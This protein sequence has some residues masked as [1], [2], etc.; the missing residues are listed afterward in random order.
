V[1]E[2]GSS[3]FNYFVKGIGRDQHDGDAAESDSHYASHVDA[4]VFMNRMPLTGMSKAHAPIMMGK[5]AFG[6][7]PIMLGMM[8]DGA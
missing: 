2:E 3:D 4:T 7:G 5:A 1:N 8:S 6:S